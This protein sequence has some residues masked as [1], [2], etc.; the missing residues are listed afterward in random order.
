MTE[1]RDLGDLL[2]AARG[3]DLEGLLGLLS[4]LDG[5]DEVAVTRSALAAGVSEVVVL[6]ELQH[7]V[8]RR[9]LRTRG[10]YD[11]REW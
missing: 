4:Q 10:F 6:E 8:E 9:L 2:D 7:E 11:E 1:P 5:A 3:L